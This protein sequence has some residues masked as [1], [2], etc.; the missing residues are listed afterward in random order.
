MNY[1]VYVS[2]CAAAAN[3]CPRLARAASVAVE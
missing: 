3:L 1:F 2:T